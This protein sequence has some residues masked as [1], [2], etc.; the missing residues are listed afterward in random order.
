MTRKLAEELEKSK[1]HG[2]GRIHFKRSRVGSTTKSVLR[3]SGRLLLKIIPKGEE[4]R[5]FPLPRGTITGVSR[6]LEDQTERCVGYSKAP[7]TLFKNSA[8]RGEI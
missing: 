6:E 4:K 5:A 1:D 7:G 2:N 3:R 8:A